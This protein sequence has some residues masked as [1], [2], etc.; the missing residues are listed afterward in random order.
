MWIPLAVNDRPLSVVLL[1]I[2]E[3][4]ADHVGRE[5]AL[6]E[7]T[8]RRPL[9]PPRCCRGQKVSVISARIFGV[10]IPVAWS[11]PGLVGNSP[12]VVAAAC[13]GPMPV[14]SWK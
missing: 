11:Y 9:P 4:E 6:L 3:V 12:L 1:D 7:L 13:S 8:G 10:P 5:R 14:M 2:G